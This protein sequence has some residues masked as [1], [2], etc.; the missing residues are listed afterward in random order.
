MRMLEVESTW[1]CSGCGGSDRAPTVREKVGKN[2]AKLKTFSCQGIIREFEIQRGKTF[3][4][5]Q[6]K[7]RE[8]CDF[9][10]FS[11]IVTICPTLESFMIMEIQPS[12]K[13][14]VSIINFDQR[15]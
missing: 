4:L 7:V 10:F 11:L 9:F 6:R 14:D 8:F 3:F 5:I 15:N 2:Q 1:R 13:I 12:T